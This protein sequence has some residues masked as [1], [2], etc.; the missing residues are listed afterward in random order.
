MKSDPFYSLNELFKF[1]VSSEHQFLN[2]MEKKISLDAGYPVLKQENPTLANLLYFQ[3][4]LEMHI[5]RLEDNIKIIKDQGGLLKAKNDRE[6]ARFD[7]DAEQKRKAAAATEELLDFFK[8]TLRRAEN[9]KSTCNQGMAVIMNNAMLAESRRA[10]F[11]AKGVAKLTLIAFFYIPLSF[12]TSFYSMDFKELGTG[13]LSLWTWF[14]T[15]VPIFVFTLCF[16]V[17]DG[18]TLRR[19]IQKLKHGASRIILRK[20]KQKFADD[21][22]LEQV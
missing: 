4:I 22:Y 1:S 2:L 15:A 12:V 10:I 14:A 5:R 8:Q 19:M 20:E 17:M 6:D 16:A 11:Q 9:L 3:K 13:K 21:I 7:L 18:P